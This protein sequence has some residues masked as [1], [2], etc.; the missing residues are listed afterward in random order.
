[1]LMLGLNETMDQLAMTNSVPYYGHVLTRKD[2][3]V[4]RKKLH[5][6]AECNRKK[7]WPKKTWKK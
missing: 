2:G 1:M 7:G 5:I 6:E 3:N 4:M